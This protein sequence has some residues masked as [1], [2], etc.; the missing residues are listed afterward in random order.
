MDYQDKYIK[1]KGGKP[2]C[3]KYR[4]DPINC[5]H[6]EEYTFNNKKYRC[7]Y[8]KPDICYR[9]KP[10]RYKQIHKRVKKRFPNIFLDIDESSVSSESSTSLIS[11][12]LTGIYGLIAYNLKDNYNFI[13]DSKNPIIN[14]FTDYKFLSYYGN[15]IV[16]TPREMVLPLTT[17]NLGNRRILFCGEIHDDRNQCINCKLPYC[18]NIYNYIVQLLETRQCIDLFIEKPVPLLKGGFMRG[19]TVSTLYNDLNIFIKK[20]NIGN[21]RIHNIDPRWFIE[22]TDKSI[23]PNRVDKP[24]LYD[25]PCYAFNKGIFRQK[26]GYQHR[27]STIVNQKQVISSVDNL[28]KDTKYDIKNLITLFIYYF[29]HP[30]VTTKTDPKIHLVNKLFREIN[31]NVS[32]IEFKNIVKTKLKIFKKY[33]KTLFYQRGVDINTFL[34]FY[35][36][37]YIKMRESDK[38][39]LKFNSYYKN[40]SLDLQTLSDPEQKRFLF[41][42]DS[43]ICSYTLDIYLLIRMFREFTN[44]GDDIKGCTFSDGYNISK[45]II[46]Y[47]GATH[48]KICNTFIKEFFKIDPVIEMDNDDNQCIKLNYPTQLFPK[49]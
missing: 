22:Y 5:L 49:E 42:L 35:I 45:N 30:D 9:I 7:S 6:Q 2:K 47:C 28:R 48:A 19:G 15:G 17:N 21:I 41:S 4:K 1:L 26:E 27:V 34:D 23:I 11:K 29:I 13:F 44:R 20:N 40:K 18:T 36:D 25:N 10:D 33:D 8:R 38:F 24:S 32:D 31:Y 43:M 12:R 46:I 39:K 14:R 37:I 16:K 3:T